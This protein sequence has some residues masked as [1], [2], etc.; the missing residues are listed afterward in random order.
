[1]SP[2]SET[3]DPDDRDARLAELRTSAR[4]R[5]NGLERDIAQLRADRGADNADD[6]HDPEGVTLSSEWAR[7]A[8]LCEDAERELA[9]VDAAIARRAAGDDGRCADCGRSIPIAR[10][11]ARPTASRCVD[12]AARAEA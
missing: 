9:E 6:E 5:L 10:L 7:L 12:C 8:G 1:M 2:P 11:L 3:S 4:A